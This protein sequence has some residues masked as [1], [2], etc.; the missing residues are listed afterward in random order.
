[1]QIKVVND[2]DNSNKFDNPRDDALKI[3]NDKPNCYK[4]RH[5]VNKAAGLG[6]HVY[7]GGPGACT[8]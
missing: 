6:H 2:E 8:Y 1:M 4:A 5:L 7:F 3:L